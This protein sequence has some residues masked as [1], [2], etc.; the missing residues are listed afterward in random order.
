[1]LRT[2]VPLTPDFNVCSKVLRVALVAVTEA[3]K[4]LNIGGVGFTLPN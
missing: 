2:L 4:T 1:M 3:C